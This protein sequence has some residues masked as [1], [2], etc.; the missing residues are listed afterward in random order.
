[1][2]GARN[3]GGSTGGTGGGIAGVAGGVV[4]YSAVKWWAICT[5]RGTW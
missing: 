1:M 3:G 5:Q 2:G 4:S